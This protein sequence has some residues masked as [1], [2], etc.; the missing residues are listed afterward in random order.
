[1]KILI[2]GSTGQ[3]GGAVIQSLLN[4]TT[5]NTIVALAR[6]ENKAKHLKEKGIEVRLGHY[7]DIVSL[8]NAMKDIS[9]VL[10]IAGTD[11]EKRV[12][13]HKNVVDSAKKTGV[14]TIAYTSRCL[15]DRTTLANELMQG[16]FLTEDYIKESKMTYL[17]FQ[18]ILYMDSIPNFLGETVFETGINVPAGNGQVSFCLRTDLAEAMAVALLKETSENKIYKLTGSNLY[19]FDDIATTLSELAQKKVTY[20]S[21]SKSEFEENLKEKNLPDFVIRRISGFLIDIANGQENQITT[22][23]EEL[24]GRKSLTL[25]EGLNRIYKL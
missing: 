6:D 12:Q 7:D 15:R 25:K 22:D 21:I 14:K 8:E 11:E 9:V 1:M 24:L 5:A 13:Q 2:T 20:T 3:L 19:S 16:H 23:L 4:H 17:L 18:N 10:L